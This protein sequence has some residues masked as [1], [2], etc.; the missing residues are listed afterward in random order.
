MKNPTQAEITK[1]EELAEHISK[2]VMRGEGGKEIIERTN[3][4]RRL[5]LHIAIKK[6]PKLFSKNIL[7]EM[8]YTR[9]GTK[10]KK[11]VHA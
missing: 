9:Q 11:K 2:K 6:N 5:A 1:I 7:E 8:G 3:R 4:G 10:R